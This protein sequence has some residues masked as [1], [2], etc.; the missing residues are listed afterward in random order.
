M[1]HASCGVIERDRLHSRTST[2]EVATL[3]ECHGMRKDPP[4]VSQSHA[5]GSNQV[6]ANPQVGLAMDEQL[7]REQEV[8]MLGHRAGQGIFDWNH[9]RANC[10]ALD[11]IEDFRGSRARHHRC[12]LQHLA[13]SL[14]A[15]RPEFPLNSYL[16]KD[17]QSIAELL[18]ILS[19]LP[20]GRLFCMVPISHSCD[21][22][23][24]HSARQRLP[25]GC[26]S[27]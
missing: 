20:N 11:Q 27:R 6:M 15:E 12:Q 13:C 9:R 5:S 19:G 10:T 26:Q 24:N 18:C 22:S 16:H 2:E 7:A 8:E 1:T 4:H 14:V 21:L 25:M 3:I 23:H 17:G